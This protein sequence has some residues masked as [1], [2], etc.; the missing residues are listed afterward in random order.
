MQTMKCSPIASSELLLEQILQRLRTSPMT[1]LEQVCLILG[2]E[3]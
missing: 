2:D 3:P 1:A